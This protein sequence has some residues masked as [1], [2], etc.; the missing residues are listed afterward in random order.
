[1][2]ILS[3]E[4]DNCPSWIGGRERMTVENISWSISMKKCCR[5]R[6][7]LNPRPSGLQ[8]TSYVKLNRVYF[9]CWCATG[10]SFPACV[11]KGLLF[12]LVCKRIVFPSGALQGVLSWHLGFPIGTVLAIFDLEVIQ[13]L[14]MYSGC[15]L[16]S[17]NCL[18]GEVKNW[19]SRWRLWRPFWIFN[20]HNFNYF[21]ST[22]QLVA[23]L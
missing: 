9:P 1:M 21:S 15:Q 12:L 16:K 5:P 8:S 6:R 18:G 3:P 19:F 11:L 23:T 4:T 2:H 10:S 13:L 7:G 14:Y 17:P 20:R 22:R